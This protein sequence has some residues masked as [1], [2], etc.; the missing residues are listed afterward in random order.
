M[1][2]NKIKYIF[3]S[4]TYAIGLLLS[5]GAVSQTFL[6]NIGLNEETVSLYTSVTLVTQV[7]AMFCSSFFSDRIKKLLKT[8]TVLILILPIIYVAFILTRYDV[9]NSLTANKIIIFS[10]SIVSNF[11]L[12]IYNVLNY[13]I[14]YRVFKIEDYGPISSVAVIISGLA[15]FGITALISYLTEQFDYFSVITVA[16]ILG[17]VFWIISAILNASFTDIYDQSK[18]KNDYKGISTIKLFKTPVFYKLISANILRGIGAGII[19]LLVTIGTKDKI[20]TEE[21]TSVH[22][23]T[24]TAGA[25][26]CGGFCYILFLKKLNPYIQLIISASIILIASPLTIVFKNYIIL[27]VGCFILNASL[28]TLG[29]C[30]PVMIYD[31]VPESI[32]GKYTAYRM[33]LFTLGQSIAGII[34]MPLFDL[35]GGTL[36]LTFGGLCTFICAILFLVVLKKEKPVL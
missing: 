23:A 4:L 27:H 1:K 28:I 15:S 5:T 31:K 9:F 3:F 32:I 20:F 36:L 14:P 30:I 25:S 33:L 6:L 22:I 7:V 35:V 11:A 21:L 19:L 13:K 34:A 2:T 17:A 24:V 29:I 8:V 18:V 10:V 16:L 12:G 26:V